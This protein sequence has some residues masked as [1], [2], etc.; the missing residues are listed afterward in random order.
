MI[1]MIVYSFSRYL[2]PVNKCIYTVINF[3]IR[4]V[5]ILRYSVV[6]FGIMK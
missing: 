1:M 5:N 2:F 3:I 4:Y 6:L